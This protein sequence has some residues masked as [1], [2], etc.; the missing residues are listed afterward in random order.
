VY[1]RGVSSTFVPVVIVVGTA[2]S[3]AIGIA[4]HVPALIPVLNVLPAFPFMIA[5]LRRGNVPDAIA[6]MVVWAAAMAVCSTTISYLAPAETANLFI[7]ADAYRREMFEFVL[8]GRGAE[9]DIRAFLPQHLM[10]AALFCALALASGSVLAMPLGAILMNY[11]GY[12][13]GALGA[14]SL[15]P[16][17]AMILAWV[18][19]A[20]IRIL[21][22][23]VLGVVLGGPLL[24]RVGGFEYEL[25]N[26]RPWILAALSGLAIDIFLKWALAPW[27]R[28]LIRA[29]AGW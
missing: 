29:A 21:S 19:W 9:G 11:M 7:H 20:V 3:Y 23:V 26:Q 10:H 6:R 15:Q 8:T 22:F 28:G 16:I 24:A 25:R 14:A 17:R 18:P 1:I 4:I 12:Y 5:A 13:V 27:W 2:L